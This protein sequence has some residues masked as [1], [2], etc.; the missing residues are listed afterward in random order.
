MKTRLLSQKMRERNLSWQ[1]TAS[2]IGLSERTMRNVMKGMTPSRTTIVAL[3]FFFEC[4]P[5]ELLTSDE[6]QD[7]KLRRLAAVG[8]TTSA[9]KT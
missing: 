1:E 2:A 6:L 7:D 9:T 5:A 8:S 3:S 4:R